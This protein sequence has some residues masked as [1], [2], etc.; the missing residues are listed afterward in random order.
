[1][2]TALITGAT[3]GIGA[4]FA[5]KLAADGWDLVLVARTAERLKEVAADLTAQH[6]VADPENLQH[7]LEV[8]HEVVPVAGRVLEARREAGQA[9]PALVD[10][11]DPQPVAE[12][13]EDG[14]VGQG[15]EAVGVGE[16]DVHRPVLGAHLDGRPIP[17]DRRQVEAQAAERETLIGAGHGRTASPCRSS[18]ALDPAAHPQA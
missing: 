10:R 7:G 9:M 2:P 17:P 15:V 3:A 1:M 5:S 8:G 16:E 6:G 11:D 4:A 12:R 14:P 18:S 13:P